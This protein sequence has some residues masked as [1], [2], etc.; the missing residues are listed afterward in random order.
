MACEDDKK[1][2]PKGEPEAQVRKESVEAVSADIFSRGATEAQ[3]QAVQEAA[4]AHKAA[5]AQVTEALGVLW[6]SQVDVVMTVGD[7]DQL[8]AVF[9]QRLK[10]FDDCSCT[11]CDLRPGPLCW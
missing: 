9:S 11:P 5:Q 4:D 1:V 3:L 7:L 10:F 2:N 8:T 6:N